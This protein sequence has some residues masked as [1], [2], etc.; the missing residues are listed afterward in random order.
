MLDQRLDMLTFS[1]NIFYWA[2]LK[3]EAAGSCEMLINKQQRTRPYFSE[4]FDIRKCGGEKINGC[5]TPIIIITYDSMEQRT[6]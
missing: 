5:H 2:T 6:S 1:L 3:K 4:H